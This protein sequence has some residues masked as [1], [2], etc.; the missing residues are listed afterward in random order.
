M[1]NLVVLVLLSG[2]C[3]TDAVPQPDVVPG[4]TGLPCDVVDALATCQGCHG[5]PPANGVPISL[6][7]YR[8]LRKTVGGLSMAELA[9]ARMQDAVAPM[10]PLPA[11]PANAAD[12]STLE[13]WVAAGMP[14]GECVDPFAVDPTC[15]SGR[16]WGGDEGPGMDPGR[17]CIACHKAERE[18]P[19]FTIAGTVY[20]TGHEPDN[21]YGSSGG[22]ITVEITG[23]DGATLMLRPNGSGNFYSSTAVMTPFTAK[24][25]ANGRERVMVTPQ[26]NGDCNACHTQAGTMDA[27][28]RIV[29][30]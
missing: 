15:T 22:D 20:P 5:T 27:P 16:T 14:P 18:G 8:D 19:Q 6:S 11:A 1:R 21:C 7:T 17:A 25:I 2:A 23:A 10:P 24:V 13:A 9:I 28:G 26:T 4:E 30:P 12:V 29:L 3:G